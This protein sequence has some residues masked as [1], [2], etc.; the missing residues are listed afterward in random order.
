MEQDLPEEAQ[1][2]EEAL[3]REVVVAGWAALDSE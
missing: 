1:E 2:L 3:D